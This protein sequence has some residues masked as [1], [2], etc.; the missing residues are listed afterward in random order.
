M[1]RLVK[2]RQESVIVDGIYRQKFERPD[3]LGERRRRG[4]EPAEV[5]NSIDPPL[6]NTCIDRLP[7]GDPNSATDNPK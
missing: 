2:K 3:T 7:N 5:R 6:E 1:R 4:V